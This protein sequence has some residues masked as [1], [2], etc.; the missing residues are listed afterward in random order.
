MA[1]KK[2]AQIGVFWGWRRRSCQSQIP[3]FFFLPKLWWSEFPSFILSDFI[4]EWS[5]H[6]YFT[7]LSFLFGIFFRDN[8]LG[9]SIWIINLFGIVSVG[10]IFE[11]FANPN[12]TG[13]CQ[14]KIGSDFVRPPLKIKGISSLIICH[15]RGIRCYG[16]FV[17]NKI[18]RVTKYFPLFSWLYSQYFFFLSLR[19]K[20]WQKKITINAG[21]SIIAQKFS[22][23]S[24]GGGGNALCGD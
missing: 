4:L 24:E 3:R 21:M 14:K 8:S 5:G 17:T 6:F 9:K 13:C 10:K 7:F 12:F 16:D 19:A 20:R 11:V 1:L 15:F 18:G 2:F 23:L 22:N